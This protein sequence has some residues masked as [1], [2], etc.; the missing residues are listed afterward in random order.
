MP[1]HLERR[2]HDEH[3]DDQ[4][5]GFESRF[6]VGKTDERSWIH[7]CES[8]FAELV[9]PA[10]LLEGLLEGDIPKRVAIAGGMD[11]VSGEIFSAVQVRGNFWYIGV[12]IDI[13]EVSFFRAMEGEISYVFG[14]PGEQK[15][16]WETEIRYRSKIGRGDKYDAR[17]DMFRHAEYRRDI[18][19][20]GTE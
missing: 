12:E 4:E 3:I 17:G 18:R 16:E 8:G 15:G 7:G 6:S 10:M 11:T 5:Y 2:K 20:Q 19:A 14:A 1:E 9:G 13:D